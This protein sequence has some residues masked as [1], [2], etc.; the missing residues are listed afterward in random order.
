MSAFSD[1]EDEA[2]VKTMKDFGPIQDAYAFFEAHTTEEVIIRNELERLWRQDGALSLPLSILDFGT[3]AGDMLERFL[4]Q[5]KI[6][7]EQ[8]SIGV[9]EPVE[10]AREVAEKRLVPHSHG[11]VASWA[12]IPAG[13]VAPFDRILS[14]HV[15]YY[16]PD[17]GKAVADLKHVMHE[18]SKLYVVMASDRNHLLVAWND[19]FAM[20]GEPV[21]FHRSGELEAALGVNRLDYEVHT[22]HSELAFEDTLENR[23]LIARFLLGDDNFRKFKGDEATQYLGRYRDEASGQIIMQLEDHIFVAKRKQ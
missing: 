6:P 5:L 8:L 7:K 17:V 19:Y 3:G 1:K 13:S 2:V 15:F 4:T 23:T 11:R 20:L 10:V 14:N 16:V 9:V 21:P 18:G 22:V 12:A